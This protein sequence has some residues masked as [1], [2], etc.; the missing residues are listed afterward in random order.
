MLLYYTPNTLEQE[1]SARRISYNCLTVPYGNLTIAQTPLSFPKSG[2]IVDAAEKKPPLSFKLWGGISSHRPRGGL[3]SDFVGAAEAR[4]HRKA[5]N[6]CKFPLTFPLME[7]VYPGKEAGEGGGSPRERFRRKN[8]PLVEE[9]FSSA[10]CKKGYR[11]AAA[12]R[13]PRRRRRTAARCP[14]AASR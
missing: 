1:Y 6:L 3:A 11:R 12:S 8:F 10:S 14:P 4:A 7:G 9:I 5:E 13:L 2:L